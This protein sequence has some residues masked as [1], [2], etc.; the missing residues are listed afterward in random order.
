LASMS[1]P[2]DN[3]KLR[4]GNTRSPAELMVLWNL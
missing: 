1:W 2:L 3:D 4:L